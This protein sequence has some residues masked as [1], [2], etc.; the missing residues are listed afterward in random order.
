MKT[1]LK[2]PIKMLNP[3]RTTNNFVHLKK[4]ILNNKQGCT[5]SLSY[6]LIFFTSGWPGFKYSE[7]VF[8]FLNFSFHTD[9]ERLNYW[10]NLVFNSTVHW[11]GELSNLSYFYLLVHHLTIVWYS[12]TRSWIELNGSKHQHLPLT[13]AFFVNIFP[14]LPT[15]ASKLPTSALT[16][17][18]VINIVKN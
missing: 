7:W 13:S 3:L 10:Y 9:L 17:G 5:K 4:N 6:I 2:N 8:I 11:L 15:I 14:N 16:F 1:K 18:T 12:I